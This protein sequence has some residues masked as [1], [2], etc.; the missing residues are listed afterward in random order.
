MAS[1]RT[2]FW[3]REALM[4][5]VRRVCA[6]EYRLLMGQRWSARHHGGTV[7]AWERR[8]EK[9]K[10]MAAC[11]DRLNAAMENLQNQPGLRFHRELKAWSEAAMEDFPERPHVQATLRGFIVESLTGLSVPAA[12]ETDKRRRSA[13]ASRPA[14]G[15]W[16][17]RSRRSL[18]SREMAQIIL[19]IGLVPDVPYGTLKASEVIR[20][21]AN[22]VAQILNRR[23]SDR[24]IDR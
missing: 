22:A 10:L 14:F 16:G 6:A 18:T 7:R 4:T 24:S 20:R 23:R 19:L 15:K 21:E 1:K 3:S 13:R 9:M 11:W 8:Y 17:T 5:D 2:P 12:V